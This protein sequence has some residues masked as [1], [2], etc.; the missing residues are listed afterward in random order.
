MLRRGIYILAPL[1]ALALVACPKKDTED[2]DDD[3]SKKTTKTEKTSEP[4]PTTTASAAPTAEIKVEGPATNPG[5][6]LRVKGEVDKRTDGI[7][8]TSLTANGAKA[9]TQGPTGWTTTKGDV[10]VTS[11]TDK[12][13]SIATTGFTG[14]AAGKLDAVAT[15]MGLTACQWNPGE[16]VTLGKDNLPGTAADGKCTKGTLAVKTAFVATEGLL[17][18]GG[19]EPDGDAT[20]VFGSLRSTA[21]AAVGVGGG[22]SACCAALRQNAKSAPPQQQGAYLLAAGACDAARNNPQTAAALA[23]VRAALAGANVPSSCR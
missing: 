6:E 12:K 15:A 21:K 18:V 4:T 7:T 10:S 16:A 5:I 19:W 13:A 23:G 2:E 17:V 11:S 1:L 14:D 20:N 9:S 22:I 8:G 3:G